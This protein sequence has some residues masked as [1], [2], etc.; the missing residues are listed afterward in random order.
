MSF[1]LVNILLLRFIV[2][3]ALVLTPAAAQA[4][5]KWFCA[6]DIA[7]SPVELL[8]V[9]C[10]D[11]EELTA[12]AIGFLVLG[13]VVEG[14]PLGRAILR[15]LDRATGLLRRH[16]ELVVRVV[17]AGFF[18]SLWATQNVLLTPELKTDLSFVPWLQ[19]AIATALVSRRTLPLAALGIAALFALAIGQYGMFH[20]MDYPVFLGLAAYL[21]CVGLQ[22][23]PFGL[24]PLD[25]LRWSGA[26]TLMWAAIEKWA[27]PQWTF[28]IFVDHPGMS[29]GI[30]I[31]YFMRAAGVVEFTLAFALLGTPL[32]RRCSAI[33]LAAMFASA[34]GEFGMIDAIGHSCIIAVMLAV[35]ADDAR[36][37]V[38]RHA[39]FLMPVSYSATLAAFVV[40]YYG[41]HTVLFGT[42]VG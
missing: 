10:Q 4:H 23:S 28:P 18:V 30:D 13:G 42:V 11:L 35:L 7:G 33:I 6:F 31:A 21:A 25:M 15:S 9:L 12:L 38:R 27:Y 8:N 3:I 36:A 34:I 16:T 1:Q 26:V 29:L 5:V 2:P 14:R 37:P 32:V 39:V 24:R 20:L 40:A 22:R 41:M 17:A 19:L